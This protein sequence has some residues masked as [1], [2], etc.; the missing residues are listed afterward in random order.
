ML[1]PVPPSQHGNGQSFNVTGERDEKLPI[2]APAARH[3]DS[4]QHPKRF[5]MPSAFPSRS[6]GPTRRGALAVGLAAGTGAV[7]AAAAPARATPT[8]EPGTRTGTGTGPS[9]VSSPARPC[10][11][12]RAPSEH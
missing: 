6:H 5:P 7:V 11:S 3:I 10:R 4:W 1:S 2:R 8:P 9:P 12:L